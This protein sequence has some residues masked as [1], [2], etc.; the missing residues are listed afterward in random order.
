MQLVDHETD[1]LQPLAILIGPSEAGWI[2]VGRRPVGTFR[3]M[4]RRGIGSHALALQ[5][6]PIASARPRFLV[7]DAEVAVA[8]LI[9][10]E[11]AIGA[12]FPGYHE[13]DMLAGG[14]PDTYMRS[15]L[16]LQLCA[17]RQPAHNVHRPHLLIRGNIAPRASSLASGRFPRTP[18]AQTR[19]APVPPR[20]SFAAPTLP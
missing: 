13:V 12:G 14:R 19:G 17:D 16:W 15:A 3:L 6:E 8:L 9:H 2:D 18:G 1:R 4:A 10:R 11:H 7:E 20:P 5:A